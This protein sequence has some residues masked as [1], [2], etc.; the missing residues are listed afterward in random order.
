MEAHQ[1]TFAATVCGSFGDKG[2]L[3][4]DEL[5]EALVHCFFEACGLSPY[6]KNP[7]VTS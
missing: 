4:F 6:K 1:S 3:N 2:D 7:S 5:L